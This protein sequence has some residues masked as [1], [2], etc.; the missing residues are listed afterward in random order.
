MPLSAELARLQGAPAEHIYVNTKSKCVKSTRIGIQGSLLNYL[1][2][3]ENRFVWLRGSPGTGKTAISLSIAFTLKST[4][5]LAASF[6]WDKKQQGRGLDSIQLFPST[7]ARQLADFNEDFKMSLIKYLRQPSLALPQDLPPETQ[8]EALIIGPMNDVKNILCPSEGRFVIVLD[9]LDECGDPMT[10]K[11]L[12]KLV[13]MLDALPLC[14]TVLVSCRPEQQVISS[15]EAHGCHIPQE[16]MDCIDQDENFR[17]IRLMIDDGLKD[18]IRRSKWKPSSEDLDMFTSSCC[19][20]P[21]LAS[22][23][24]RDF[25]TQLK[26]GSNLKSEFKYIKNAPKDVNEEYLRTL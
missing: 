16:D 5:T 1:K 9:G 26:R 10:L 4:G 25:C 22:I 19:G 20:L 17:T 3:A 18:A 21:I 7:L 6:F 13:L 11:K 2:Q 15:W 14:F 12:M 8:M 23:R 24:I